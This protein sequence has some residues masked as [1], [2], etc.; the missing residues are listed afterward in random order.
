MS[1]IT[2]KSTEE[3]PNPT[4]FPADN[5]ALNE[6][7]R[8]AWL[9]TH[10]DQLMP[11]ERSFATGCMTCGDKMAYC[12]D[13]LQPEAAKAALRAT[14]DDNAIAEAAVALAARARG[15]PIFG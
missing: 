7:D 14:G 13:C 5:G 8:T 4:V 12:Y 3:H 1:Y 6:A 9:T 2:L 10:R 11:I 15:T